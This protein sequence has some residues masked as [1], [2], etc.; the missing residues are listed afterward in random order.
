M[1]KILFV[2]A[3]GGSGEI[4][5]VPLGLLYLSSYIRQK[6]Y[7][8]FEIKLIDMHI[9]NLTPRQLLPVLKNYDPLILGISAC[10]EDDRVLHEIAALAKLYNKKILTV[11]GGP[12]VTM[13]HREILNDENIDLAVIGE[14]EIT[15]S[16]ILCHLNNDRDFSGIKGVAYKRD[17]KI[18]VNPARDFF[19]N[20]DALPFP[21]WDLIDIEKYHRPRYRNF[22]S[23]VGGHRHMP[24]ITS[25]G[26]PYQCIYCHNLFGKT[27]RGRSPENVF[28]EIEFLVKKYDIDEFQIWDDIFNEDRERAEKICDKIIAS[29]LK[30]KLSFP[31]G[32]RGDIIDKQ[33]I[34]KLKKS[35]AYSVTFAIE[36]ASE[37]IQELTKKY[38]AIN[39][40]LQNIRYAEG[41]GLITRGFF[42]IGFPSESTKEIKQTIDLACKSDLSCAS[43]FIAY[44]QRATELFNL[45]KKTYSEFDGNLP[46]SSYNYFDRNDKYEKMLG[47]PLKKI[48]RYAFLKFYINP[49]RVIKIFKKIPRKN[50]F[51]ELFKLLYRS[52]K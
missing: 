3:Y 41:I 1:K 16:E 20:L 15:F 24:L 26:C 12:H 44:P 27:F 40:V 47:I 49:V 8:F 6:F 45:V 30:I 21:A 39:K 50:G 28:S 9:D 42:M 34:A 14:G 13:Y 11:A 51:F 22:H 36:S 5:I 25:R 19:E 32:L 48:Q 18:Y 23:M 4:G 29:G 35:G 52:I 2:K 43:F 38:I 31:N 33:L 37:R 10:S 46:F 17:G 7:N